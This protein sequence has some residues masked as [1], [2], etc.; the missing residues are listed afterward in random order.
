MRAAGGRH[1]WI[2]SAEGA[3]TLVELTIPAAR[4]YA[5]ASKLSALVAVNGSR[6]LSE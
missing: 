4:A 3:G 1:S 5:R 2:R 6:E